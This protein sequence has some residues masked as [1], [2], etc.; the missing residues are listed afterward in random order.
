MWNDPA[1]F[2][3][4]REIGS[5]CALGLSLS[6]R[7]SLLPCLLGRAG[8]PLL[9]LLGPWIGRRLACGSRRCCL[10]GTQPLD[11]FRE[12]MHSIVQFREL[13]RVLARLAASVAI[14]P[15]LHD[16]PDQL[17]AIAGRRTFP[18]SARCCP[19]RQFRTT[20]GASR[21]VAG[22]VFQRRS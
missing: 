20:G 17:A 12:L 13:L 6:G 22:T 14:L 19:L 2:K 21:I 16:A 15:S 18:L 8:P 5:D 11:F 4:E 7:R 1:V 9:G 10:I 3:L